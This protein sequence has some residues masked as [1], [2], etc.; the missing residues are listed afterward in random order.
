M[1]VRGDRAEDDHA[2]EGRGDPRGLTEVLGAGHLERDVDA[3]AVGQLEDL[4]DRT[5]RAVVDSVVDPVVP[6]PAGAF[7]GWR[8]RR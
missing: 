1:S 4:L 7:P 5:R 2:A 6:E 8:R 3:T